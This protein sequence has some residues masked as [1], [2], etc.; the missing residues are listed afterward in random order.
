MTEPNRTG[1]RA[2]DHADLL[3]GAPAVADYMNMTERQARYLMDKGS[4]PSFKIDGKVCSTR[5]DVDAWLA[6]ARAKAMRAARAKAAGEAE[7]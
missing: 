7:S 6:E 4:L 1:R 5:G 3:Y 2:G